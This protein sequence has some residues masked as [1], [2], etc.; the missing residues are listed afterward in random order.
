MTVVMDYPSFE[1]STT[2]LDDYWDIDKNDPGLYGITSTT[3]W[4]SD[5]TRSAIL[6][7]FTCYTHEIG[8]Y[9]ALYTIEDVTVDSKFIFEI[10][11]N[12]GTASSDYDFIIEFDT[13]EVYSTAISSTGVQNISFDVDIPDGDY[14]MYIKLKCIGNHT[15]TSCKIYVDNIRFTNL[16]YTSGRKICEDT[17][18]VYFGVPYTNRWGDDLNITDYSETPTDRVTMDFTSPWGTLYED[19]VL[20]EDDKV[21][22]S[23]SV[24]GG[25]EY[26]SVECTLIFIGS[27]TAHAEFTLCYWTD[28]G[29]RYVTTSGSDSNDGLSWDTPY[30]HVGYGFQHLS[31][32]VTPAE[33]YVEH[34]TYTGET[35]S[36]FDPSVDNMEM[37]IQPTTH[38]EGACTV[39]ITL[40]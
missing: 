37:I 38:V 8:D 17:E 20:A 9:V 7:E 28:Y 39:T 3:D 40:A 4:S 13:T 36:N 23:H 1:G 6:G 5:G 15:G 35:A 25:K 19:E 27:E 29:R 34:G 12:V 33:L 26:Y 2:T 16:E 24:T 10:D 30:R 31:T 18:E 21:T 22:V 14:T 32:D 11:L